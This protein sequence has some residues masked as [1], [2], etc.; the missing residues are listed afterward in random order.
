MKK[1]LAIISI[2]LAI[3]LL[4]C[5]CAQRASYDENGICRVIDGKV[6]EERN[7]NY[8]LPYGDTVYVSFDDY[9]NKT[10]EKNAP[11]MES[12]ILFR[13]RNKRAESVSLSDAPA[14]YT[15]AEI[16]ILEIYHQD[17]ELFSNLTIGDSVDVLLQYA[18]V[19]EK[20][21]AV[22]KDFPNLKAYNLQDET[23]YWDIHPG[24]FCFDYVNSHDEYLVFLD[25]FM[26]SKM[27]T[28]NIEVRNYGKNTPVLLTKENVTE[29]HI[30]RFLW[31][32]DQSQYET[33]KQEKIFTSPET[34]SGA[35]LEDLYDF[36]YFDIL[37]QY[38][39]G[40]K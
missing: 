11:E 12:Y 6:P 28:Q 1:T 9:V 26:Y 5:S 8:I 17:G 20:G 2:F 13:A 31:T 7:A 32:I 15:I 30:P 23:D 22:L 38:I 37:D 36:V 3:V 18:F 10:K 14:G 33:M 24:A 16:E 25:T 21:K 29:L 4:L 35:V 34:R 39:F 27:Q 40:E 19:P